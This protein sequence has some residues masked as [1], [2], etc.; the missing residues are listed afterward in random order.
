[1][2]RCTRAR[3]WQCFGDSNTHTIVLLALFMNV[4]CCL[5]FNVYICELVGSINE[6][7]KYNSTDNNI[8]LCNDIFVFV[9]LLFCYFTFLLFHILTHKPSSS[10]G[11]FLFPWDHFTNRWLTCIYVNIID[12]DL[13]SSLN[14]L[15]HH[16]IKSNSS[17]FKINYQLIINDTVI[18][19]YNDWI[20]N[21]ANA[22]C[23]LHCDLPICYSPI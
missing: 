4:V 6:T 11:I 10:N 3:C 23:N 12:P 22:N 18:V 16:L 9:I 2:Y 13:M 15:A 7:D 14:H 20:S 8:M 1:M 19:N 21:D 17:L 5:Y